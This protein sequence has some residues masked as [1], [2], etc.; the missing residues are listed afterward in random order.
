[1]KYNIEQGSETG[2]ETCSDTL[3]NKNWII[4]IKSVVC[5]INL[6]NVILLK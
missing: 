1:M 2:S 6:I 3:T 4:F 5:D